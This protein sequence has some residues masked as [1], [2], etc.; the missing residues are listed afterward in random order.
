MVRGLDAGKLQIRR[1]VRGDEVM[2]YRLTPTSR[3]L[4]ANL[5][6]EQAIAVADELVRIAMGIKQA[7]AVKAGDA[8]A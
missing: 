5:S 8:S 7:N 2:V 6:P 3:D 1:S 4:V